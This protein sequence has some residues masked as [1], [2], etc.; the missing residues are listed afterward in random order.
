VLFCR[1]RKLGL[2]N[3]VVIAAA[4]LIV[5]RAAAREPCACHTEVMADAVRE[6]LVAG[7]LV[8]SDGC[9]LLV[10][11]QR[12]GGSEDWSTP[13]GVIDADDGSV[14]AGL[15]REVEEETGLRVTRWEGPLYEVEAF[16][17][18]LGWLMRC[19][20]HRAIDYVGEVQV[21]DPD[22]IVVE[23]AFVPAADAGAVLQ[24]CH[25]WVGE[26]ITEWL[27]EPWGPERVR[28]YRYEVRGTVRA[29]LE[30]TRTDRRVATD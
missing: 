15:T 29:A 9:L 2:C 24:R 8:E 10:R 1:P 5:R 7:A 16:A 20:V 25:P 21:A 17:P 30:V 13:G 4:A 6:W 27:A 3:G 28:R 22:G 19:E 26:P 11:N 23:A 14:L 12:R 18:D